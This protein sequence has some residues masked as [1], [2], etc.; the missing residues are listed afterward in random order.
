MVISRFTR[1]F[2]G[3]ASLCFAG[4]ALVIWA[5]PAE[6][7]RWLG[8]EAT[9]AAGVAALRSD[10]GGLFTAL[11]LFCGAAAWTSRPSYAR[12]AA[13][14]LL[15]IV[16]GRTLGWFATGR[17][18]VDV[19]EMGVEMC[20][21]TALV[22]LSR[23]PASS[24]GDTPLARRAAGEFVARRRMVVAVV[25]FGAGVAA[26]GTLLMP[27]TQQ[28]LYAAGAA[29]RTSTVNTAP[30]ADD[31]LRVAVCGS[32]APL[33]SPS[34][35]KSCVAVFAG[36]RFYVVD[37]GP[38]STENLVL[39]GIPLSSVGGVLLTHFHS[40]HIG[41][42][43]ELNLQT[44]AG[45]RREPLRVYGGPGVERVV[46]G[47]NAA[48]RL[49]QGYR[50]AH[51]SERVM[52]SATWPMT[53]Q[54][55][56]MDGRQGPAIGRTQVVLEQQGLRITAVT[57]NHAPIAPAYAYRFDYKGRSAFITGDLTFD[58]SLA[59]AAQGVDLFLSEAIAPAMTRAL[60]A[61]ARAAG[62]ENTAA[63]MHDIEDY[64]I[65]PEQAADAANAAGARLLAF[66]HLLPAPD[67][68]LARRV[69]SAGVDARR[70]GDWT[71]AHDGSLYTMPIG[72]TEVHIGALA[73]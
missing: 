39:W 3:L 26:L 61:G 16:T 67:N 31:A 72:S 25:V 35:A 9:R 24:P 21:L 28:R 38:E 62:R 40:D 68:A 11:A 17:A 20:L 51:H 33:P 52:P 36:G 14:L 4:A 42:L 71:L 73:P 23:Q 6:A 55:V 63:V 32:S 30:L 60:G 48:Y 58:P 43:G 5:A 66:Y 46:E 59:R 65:S 69:F 34:R 37:A 27:S 1:M 53:A 44:W 18:P 56:A 13:A 70:Q 8:L 47:F 54:I 57:V 50:T 19:V 12:T 64:H 7:G 29:R 22:M 15:A 2:V 10:L 49:D 41:D 45:G